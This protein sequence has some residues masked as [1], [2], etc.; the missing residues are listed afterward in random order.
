[1][2][3]VT[4]CRTDVATP[5]MST[6]LVTV[7]F[8][9]VSTTSSAEVAGGVLSTIGTDACRFTFGSSVAQV[10]LESRHKRG[11]LSSFVVPSNARFMLRSK[12]FVLSELRASSKSGGHVSLLAVA[13]GP[14]GLLSCSGS[15]RA[16][17]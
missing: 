3:L 17:S 16:L 8:T 10:S 2:R 6:G 13:G 7:W 14:M 5:V 9:L 15:P 1:M 11:K 4:V 12:T